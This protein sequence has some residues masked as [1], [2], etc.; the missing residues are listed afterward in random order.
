MDAMHKRE[1]TGILGFFLEAAK[2]F[3]IAIACLL[4]IGAAVI[5]SA[6]TGIGIPARW[7]GLLFWT[8]AL[9]WFVFRQHRDDHR[10]AIFWLALTAV[11]AV[12]VTAFSVVLRAYAAW[13]MIWFMF[14]F[15][16][17]GP[18]VLVLLKSVIHPRRVRNTSKD[19]G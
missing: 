13:P 11:L 10:L 12:H 18:L 1:R 7:F 9:L 15:M 5:V 8:A 19:H 3:G 4:V 14:I 17:E 6:K 2:L 16:I